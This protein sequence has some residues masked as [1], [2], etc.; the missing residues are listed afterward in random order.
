LSLFPEAASQIRQERT[1]IVDENTARL[2]VNLSNETLAD[3]QKIKDLLSHTLPEAGFADVIA[4]LAKDYLAREKQR[5]EKRKHGNAPLGRS[6]GRQGNHGGENKTRLTP[7]LRKQILQRDECCTYRDPKT[8]KTCGSTYQLQVDHIYPK[9]LG[10]ADG[11]RNLRVLCRKHNVHM[12]E[13]TL[14]TWVRRYPRTRLS[15]PASS[16]RRW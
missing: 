15:T 6:G 14:G 11:A 2:A 13:K 12:A 10:G 5:D 16:G 9:A 4:H 1:T 3:L 8:G 7:R